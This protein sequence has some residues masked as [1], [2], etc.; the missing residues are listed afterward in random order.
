MKELLIAKIEKATEL[1]NYTKEILSLS[2]KTDY[3]KV[4][5][6]IDNR[7]AFMEDID[8]I[9]LQIKAINNIVENDEIKNL[10]KELRGI[11]KE[12]TELD[13][14]MRNKLNEELKSVKKNLNKPEVSTGLLN[15][16][17]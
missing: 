14:I 3:M 13:N 6:M 17:A 10:K 2:L 9:D 15:L 16:K 4:Q 8:K 5:S 1:K 7:Q 11:F 12:I